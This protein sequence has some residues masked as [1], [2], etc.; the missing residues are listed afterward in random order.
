MKYYSSR[1]KS[2]RVS[3]AEAIV[4]GLA[5][6]GGLFLPQRHSSVMT[7]QLD[8]ID[9]ETLAVRI[10]QALFPDFTEKELLHYVQAAYR[11]SFDKGDIAPLTRTGQTFTAELWH[12]PTAAFKDVALSLLPY[13]LTAAAKKCGITDEIRILTA[14]SGDTG[15]A[16][17]SGFGGVPGTTI[18]VF[19]PAGGVSPMQEHQMVSAP[20]TNT[21]VCAVRGNFDDAQTGVKKILASTVPP[22]GVRFSSA[23]SI[24]IGR[25]APQIIYYFKSYRELLRT[26]A[27]ELGAPVD[28][29]VPTGNFG[30]IF[31]GF[32]AK[33]M[34]LPVGRLICASNQNHILT[35]FLT[36]G[37]YDRRREFLLS[38][39]PSMDIL[40]SSN[41]ER[42]LS[43]T[44]GTRRT[45]SWMQ[46]LSREG[47]FDVGPDVL[48]ALREHFDAGWCSE[49]ETLAEIRR[50]WQEDGY[51]ID[52]HTAV[53]SAVGRRLR[54]EGIP[55]V[56]LSTASPFK[57]SGAVLRALGAPAEADDR[58]NLKRLADFTGVTPPAALLRALARPVRHKNLCSPDGME[59]FVLGMG[60]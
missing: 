38:C 36:A 47:R 51:L 52:P 32:L 4:A 34:G 23:N 13:L 6:D 49:E 15:S 1:K 5:P 7:A 14:T 28:F 21:A 18:A 9:D 22:A 31:A 56:V 58:L 11:T 2:I 44:A 59:A 43:L 46:Q 16:A 30:D 26:G 3:P 39:S 12:G 17:L 24:N 53:A 41:L 10:L 33:K 29:A 55:L 57:F 8:K 35:D 20:G 54:R 27:V 37:V 50:S 48:A 40:V 60:K 19:Y 25:L 45:A 42:L